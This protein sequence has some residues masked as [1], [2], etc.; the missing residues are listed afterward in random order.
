MLKEFDARLEQLYGGKFSAIA[1]EPQLLGAVTAWAQSFLQQASHKAV[2]RFSIL[3]KEERSYWEDERF[4]Y[5]TEN[6]PSQKAH[7]RAARV[8]DWS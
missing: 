4:E 8:K 5:W 7:L 2:R 3:A 1:R 6:E